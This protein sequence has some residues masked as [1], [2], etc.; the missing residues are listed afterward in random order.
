MINFQ[1][2]ELQDKRVIEKCLAH[3]NYQ[4]CDLCFA[5]LYAWKFRFGTE[6]AIVGETL[7]I[8]FRDEIGSPFYL[9]P[10]GKMPLEKAFDLIIDDARQTG[11][12]FAVKGVSSAM[13]NDIQQ[14]MPDKFRYVHN[15]DNAEYIYLTERLKTLTGK[16]LQSKR[17]HI[18]RF[19]T[20]N[21]DWEYFPLTSR[22]ELD[23]C[24]QML[25]Q[26]EDVKASAGTDG[27]SDDYIATRTMLQQ[28]F[29]LDLCGGAI[30]VQGKVVAFALGEPVNTDTYVVHVEKAY[31]ALNGSYAIINQQTAEHC[32][33]HFKYINRE[34]DMGIEN[35]RKAKLS[36]QPEYLLEEGILTLM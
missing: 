10:I 17:N 19:K 7:F 32:A 35:L 3:H 24:L 29:E 8:R 27:L 6:Y 25:E 11:N 1:P 16:K 31:A 5:N 9:M 13:Y 20:D 26:W 36:Y 4:S 2:I 33:A 34:E 23:E 18:N 28:F 12:T 21:P 22:H 14:A 15:R 30:R